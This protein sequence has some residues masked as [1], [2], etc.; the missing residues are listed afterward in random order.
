MEMETGNNVVDGIDD[1][2]VGDL[3]RVEQWFFGTAM[4]DLGRTDILEH[5][6]RRSRKLRTLGHEAW[7]V[8]VMGTEHHRMDSKV[9]A[10]QTVTQEETWSVTTPSPD[11]NGG[12]QWLMQG[13]NRSGEMAAS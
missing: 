5:I 7:K 12:R 4:E 11:A 1:D 8:L 10:L 9:A 6:N 2:T 13:Q 3:G